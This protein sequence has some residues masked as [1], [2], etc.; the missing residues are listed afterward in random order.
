VLLLDSFHG[1]SDEFCLLFMCS[2][3]WTFIKQ[4]QTVKHHWSISITQKSRQLK[5][6]KGSKTSAF[7]PT[8]TLIAFPNGKRLV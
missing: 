5:D 8:Q 2:M 6:P 3:K 4:S 7:S 1:V